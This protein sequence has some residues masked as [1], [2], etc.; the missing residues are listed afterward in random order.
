MLLTLLWGASFLFIEVG[1]ESLTPVQVALSRVTLGAVALLA[2]IGLFVLVQLRQSE[3]DGLNAK[4]AALKPK[5]DDARG[6]ILQLRTIDAAGAI[7]DP[8]AIHVRSA[9]L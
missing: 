2:I 1:L 8:G 3:L 7:L 9:I 4:A 6:A 5:L